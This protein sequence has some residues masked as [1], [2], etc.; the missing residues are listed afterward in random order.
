MQG[1]TLSGARRPGAGAA[2]DVEAYLQRV[3]SRV[4]LHE[5]H[6]EISAEL[7]DH[8]ACALDDD[9][10]SVGLVLARLGAAE[11]LGDRL[12]AVYRPRNDT[13]L[14]TSAI[15]LL[16]SGIGLLALVVTTKL[17]S[18]ATG[19][20]LLAHALGAAL[21]LGLAALLWRADY[22]Q[23]QRSGIWLLPLNAAALLAA[24]AFGPTFGGRPYLV[25]S[26]LRLDVVG[27]SPLFLIV[28]LVSVLAQRAPAFGKRHYFLAAV[29]LAP[30]VILPLLGGLLEASIFLLAAVVV[31]ARDR[32]A[33]V[34]LALCASFGPLAI[35]LLAAQPPAQTAI[36]GALPYA[37]SDYLV[38]IAL[39]HLGRWAFAVLIVIALMLLLRIFALATRAVDPY[40]RALA[41]GVGTIFAATMTYSLLANVG[42]VLLPKA[43]LVFPLCGY[44]TSALFVHLAAIGLLLGVS[45]LQSVSSFAPAG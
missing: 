31:L 45:R 23:L 9:E 27:V 16:L 8:I 5:A 35:V 43:G 30:V 37:E 19:G 34:A 2:A 20:K 4:A 1:E 41:T 38:G 13:W 24:W 18:T 29:V 32:Y 39:A 17:S 25:L 40:G 3:V 44:G 36:V 11:Q 26:A 6:A 7:R 22:R 33:R 12:A 21:G 14:A 15:G 42:V 10:T 28:G